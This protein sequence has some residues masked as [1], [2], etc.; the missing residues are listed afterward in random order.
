M[1]LR[2]NYINNIEQVL[3]FL[4]TKVELRGSM[5]LYDINIHAENFYRDLFNLIYDWSLEDLNVEKK[6]AS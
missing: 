5:N 4:R 2:E 3:T 6:N 1:I